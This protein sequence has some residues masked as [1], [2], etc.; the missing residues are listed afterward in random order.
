MRPPVATVA[1]AAKPTVAP[2]EI[3]TTALTYAFTTKPTE[4]PTAKPAA[5]PNAKPAAA[6]TAKPTAVAL[7][8]LPP[9]TRPP[10]RRTRLR[11]LLPA[12]RTSPLQACL[13][14]AIFALRPNRSIHRC[15]TVAGLL[16][17]RPSPTLCECVAPDEELPLLHSP[18]PIYNPR[19]RR[20]D[21]G[22]QLVQQRR[23][24]HGASVRLRAPS[25]A[26]A[27]LLLSSQGNCCRTVKYS[28]RLR[29]ALCGHLH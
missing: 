18:S 25:S 16:S 17:R 13:P 28:S 1:P 10:Q 7:R 15:V 19:M 4:D 27:S 8:S 26:I 12:P 20:A 23:R 22:A 2:T 9:P 14:H 21:T 5:A 11:P 3:P 6:P 29:H 24:R